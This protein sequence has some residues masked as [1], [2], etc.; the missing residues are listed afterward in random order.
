MAFLAVTRLPMLGHGRPYP[1]RS[2]SICLERVLFYFGVVVHESYTISGGPVDT[3][4]WA[5]VANFVSFC[6]L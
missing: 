5:F 3:L 1:F 6:L 4:T 2:R